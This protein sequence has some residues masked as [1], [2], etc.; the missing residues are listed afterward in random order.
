MENKKKKLFYS[1]EVAQ[2]SRGFSLFN[3]RGGGWGWEY[4]AMT[5]GVCE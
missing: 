5:E 1:A 3:D 2:S 4:G